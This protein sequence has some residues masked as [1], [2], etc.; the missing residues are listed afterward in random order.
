MKRLYQ[1][2]FSFRKSEFEKSVLL[3]I[4]YRTSKMVLFH[5]AFNHRSLKE[6]P[7]ENNERMEFLGDAIIS[8][9][10]AG[11]I[12]RY[13]NKPWKA[14]NLVNLVKLGIQIYDRISMLQA[15]ENKKAQV[16]LALAPRVTRSVH[17]EVEEKHGNVLFV[18]YSTDDLKKLTDKFS[19]SFD[20]TSAT[21]VDE[22]FKE[23]A[24]K[25]ISVVV[26]N[27]NFGDVVL[28]LSP[29]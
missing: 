19:K 24:K 1:L 2:L 6:N 4:G 5:T 17:I 10:N 18:D 28:Y 9:V 12:F 21:S 8:S 14:D 26:S 29:T 27:V 25:P 22:A 23:L 20:V 7:S 13:I 16:D 11:E 15:Q 3:L